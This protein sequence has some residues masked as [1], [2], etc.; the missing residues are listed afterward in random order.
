[1]PI[2]D[3]PTKTLMLDFAKDR[4]TPTRVFDKKERSTGSQSTIRT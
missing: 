4:L 3:K 2:Y 1:M